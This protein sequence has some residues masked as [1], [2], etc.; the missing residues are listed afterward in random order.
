[1]ITIITPTYKRNPDVLRR[2]FASINGQTYPSWQHL[3]LVDDETVEPHVSAVIQ[4][5]YA[6]ARRSFVAVGR[7]NNSGNTPRQRGIE[8]AKGEYIV[9][10]DDDNVIFPN[11][12]EV[13]A[14]YMAEHRDVMMGICKIV[15]L[16][17]L[18]ARL[19]PPPIILA[20]NPP[21]L[22][23]I[24]TLQVCVRREIAQKEGWMVEKGYMADGWTFQTW[25]ERHPYGYVDAI[26]GI[27]M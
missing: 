19:C 23:N 15:H 27:H 25:A 18:P 8:A 24:D 16:G 11:Y 1:M 4:G 13:F 14:A 22:Q 10:V 12:L 9:F 5:D 20:G 3:V 26:L 21:V 2:C 17:P 6:D 7:H